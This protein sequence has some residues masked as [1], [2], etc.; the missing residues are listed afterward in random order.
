MYELHF[1]LATFSGK[2]F[3]SVFRTETISSPLQDD[4]RMF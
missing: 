2:G 4:K 1:V 3:F